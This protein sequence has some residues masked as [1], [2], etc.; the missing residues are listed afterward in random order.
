MGH[1]PEWLVFE[2]EGHRWAKPGNDIAWALKV[3]A[4][5]GKHLGPAA[6]QGVPMN[7]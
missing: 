5:L 4:F 6:P 2:R 3:E 1:E 7:K